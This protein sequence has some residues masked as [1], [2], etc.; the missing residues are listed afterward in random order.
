MSYYSIANKEI[1]ELVERFDLD[2]LAISTDCAEPDVYIHC[3]RPLLL[4]ELRCIE[5]LAMELHTAD[6]CARGEL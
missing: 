5:A 6:L 2:D 3:G 1:A 4:G